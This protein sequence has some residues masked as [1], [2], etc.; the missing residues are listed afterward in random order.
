VRRP[1]ADVPAVVFDRVSLA[2]DENVV[3]REISFTVRAGSM[4]ILIGA[5][6]AGES[7]VLKL[8]L[9]LLK[10]DSGTIYV[11]GERINDMT[12]AQMM[13]VRA[14]NGMLFQQSALFDS[15]TVA[16]NVGYRLD[17]ETDMPADLPR[18]DYGQ[19]G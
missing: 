13:K 9:G 6:G 14:D 12:E 19:D 5:S 18:P 3:L 1:G 10:P 2:F 7:V 11:N 4:T 16:G 15:L 17:E 8:L